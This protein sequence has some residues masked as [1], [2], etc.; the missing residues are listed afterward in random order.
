VGNQISVDLAVQN[1]SMSVI[2]TKWNIAV[3][4]DSFAQDAKL[5][6]LVKPM[7]H[8]EKELPFSL[9]LAVLSNYCASDDQQN[10]AHLFPDVLNMWRIQ[11]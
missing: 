4:N 3:K 7:A 2:S 5:F 8:A 10:I 9:T 11:E 6:R 1:D